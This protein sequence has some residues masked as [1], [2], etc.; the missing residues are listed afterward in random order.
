[1][2]CDCNLGNARHRNRFVVKINQSPQNNKPSFKLER[3]ELP[4][5]FLGV[6]ILINLFV[7]LY[8][9]EI[10]QPGYTSNSYL[11]SLDSNYLK[12]V[13]S[14]ISGV[15]LWCVA[16]ITVTLTLRCITQKHRIHIEPPLET[17]NHNAYTPV[18]DCRSCGAKSR[19]VSK[20]CVYCGT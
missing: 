5:I 17:T 6:I 3:L 10:P 20:P 11:P 4:L 19:D 9:M 13:L 16:S 18:I 12:D 2:T 8:R 1:M 14:G 7:E 15:L